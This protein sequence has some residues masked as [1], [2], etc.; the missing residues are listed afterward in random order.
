MHVDDATIKGMLNN[1]SDP[2][3]RATYASILNGDFPYK[4]Y[5][6]NPQKNSKGKLFH[7][8]GA[9]IGY[10]D[11]KHKCIDEPRIDNNGVPVSGIE[12]SRDRLDGRKGFRCYC[13]NWSIEAREEQGS[14]QRGLITGPPTK[15]DILT[16]HDKLQKSGK[17]LGM[18]FSGGVA[19]YDGFLVRRMA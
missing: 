12:T 16:I 6:M 5:C 2:G 15:K 3:M 13:G 4:V 10:M 19:E 14:I 1:I 7:K 9:L 11:G 17:K 8:K 18:Q